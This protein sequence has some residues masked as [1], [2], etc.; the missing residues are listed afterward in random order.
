M[1]LLSQLWLPIIVSAVA[2]W[3]AS[4]VAWMALPHHKK[5]WRPM[6]DEAAFFRAFDSLK[7]PPGN[8]GFPDCKDKAKRNDPEVKRRWEAGEMGLLSIWG[9]MSM[10]RNMV[11]T[12]IV[13]LAISFFVA[14]IGAAAVKPGA[15]FSQAFQVLGAAGVLAYA[16]SHIPGSVWF[17]HYPRAILMCVLDGIVYGLIT[18]AV[19]AAMWP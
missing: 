15:T 17:N 18:G 16:F 6:P 13:Y 12:F 5:D 14:Y 10:G 7:F 2:V 8:Y 19:F 9:K 11:V 1:E 3:V 4:A